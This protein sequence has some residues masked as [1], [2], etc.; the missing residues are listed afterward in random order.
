MRRSKILD[1]AKGIA[2]LHCGI[3]PS[4]Y[5]RDIRIVEHCPQQGYEGSSF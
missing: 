5:H 4:I 1:V 2:Y 3:K